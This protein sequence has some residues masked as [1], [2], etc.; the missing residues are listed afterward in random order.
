M[1]GVCLIMEL[2]LVFADELKKSKLFI[3]TEIVFDT[4]PLSHKAF[5]VAPFCLHA[6]HWNGSLSQSDR[7]HH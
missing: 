6:L 4:Y 3:G 1:S 2:N 7:S 5:S